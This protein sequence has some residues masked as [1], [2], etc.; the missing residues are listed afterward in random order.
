MLLTKL[1]LYP[2][3]RYES[4]YGRLR[5]GKTYLNWDLR[6]R[7]PF[8]HNSVTYLY[9][10]HVIEHLEFLETVNFLSESFRVLKKGGIIRI[11]VPDT[12]K[13]AKAYLTDNRDFFTINLPHIDLKNNEAAIPENYIPM[14]DILRTITTTGQLYAYHLY[15]FGHKWGYDYPSI[16]VMLNDAGFSHVREE[17]CHHSQI[18][19]IEEVEQRGRSHESLYVEAVK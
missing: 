8:K 7:L 13:L 6:K 16:E 18:P 2:K 10:E 12:R 9:S 15:R 11:S 3:E 5:A 17:T 1:G 19:D 4:F 14:N